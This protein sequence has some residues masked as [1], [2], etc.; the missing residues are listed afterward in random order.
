M[1]V[2][3]PRWQ[4][5]TA[6]ESC[7]VKLSQGNYFVLVGCIGESECSA[8]IICAVCGRQVKNSES[9]KHWSIVFKSCSVVAGVSIGP[10]QY[11]LTVRSEI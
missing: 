5:S 7:A 1:V 10:A 4:D 2:A 6:G 8:P 3:Q 11:K 9:A